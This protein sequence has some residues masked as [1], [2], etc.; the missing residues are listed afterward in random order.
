MN[1][2]TKSN[3][4]SYIKELILSEIQKQT[5]SFHIDESFLAIDPSELDPLDQG[6]PSWFKKLT[7]EEIEFE[8][9]KVYKLYKDAE[10]HFKNKL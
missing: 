6:R 8:A 2:L 5:N 1:D 4:I 7:E 3:Q 10:N 9:L